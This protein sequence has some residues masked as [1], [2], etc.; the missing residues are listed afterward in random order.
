MDVFVHGGAG[1]APAQP[2]DRQAVLDEAATAGTAG[3]DPV[4][5]VIEAVTVLEESPR[6]NAGIGSAVQSDGRIRTDAGIM[7]GDGSVGAACGMPDVANAIRVADAV[8]TETPHVLLCGEHAV[9][10][11]DRFEIRTDVDLWTDRRRSQWENE[12]LGGASFDTQVRTVRDRFG[13][14]ADTVGAVAS[15]G[16]RVAAATSTGG[17]WLALAGRVGDVPQVGCGFFASTHGAV[18]TTGAGEGI[19]SVT[20]AR[21]AERHLA[22]SGDPQHAAEYSLRTFDTEAEGSAGLIVITPDGERGSAYSSEV[23]QT[24]FAAV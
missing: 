9:Q 4:D 6:F 15:D 17:R 22:E 11:A 24:A 16:S 10:F 18:S 7:T 23:M 13:A 1:S 14:G 19:A 21:L 8:R 2:D 20:L 12:D 5:A 3:A